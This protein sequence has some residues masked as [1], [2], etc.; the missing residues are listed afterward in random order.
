M[1]NRERSLDDSKTSA[2]TTRCITAL[3]TKLTTRKEH[4]GNNMID[5]YG[6]GGVSYLIVTYYGKFYAPQYEDYPDT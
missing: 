5:N 6:G 3:L 1:G 2:L 4:M